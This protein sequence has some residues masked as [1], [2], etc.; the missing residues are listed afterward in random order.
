[1]YAMWE[2]CTC[3]DQA[4]SEDL[5]LF[6]AQFSFPQLFY[7]EQSLGAMPPPPTQG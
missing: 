7:V 4:L 3:E 5:S 6:L 1:M 2:G